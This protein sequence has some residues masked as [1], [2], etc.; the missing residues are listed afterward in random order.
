MLQDH[1]SRCVNCDYGGERC[2]LCP[3]GMA[4]MI[5]LANVTKSATCPACHL[6][7]CK[8][9][10]AKHMREE[11]KV[12]SRVNVLSLPKDGASSFDD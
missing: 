7:G 6:K 8:E 11:H 1:L 5:N 4:K 3:K 2:Q 10:V 9:C 12:T